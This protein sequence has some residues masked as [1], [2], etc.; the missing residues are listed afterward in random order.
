MHTFALHSLTAVLMET[1]KQ[2][3]LQMLWKTK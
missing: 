3:V 2:A 1:D